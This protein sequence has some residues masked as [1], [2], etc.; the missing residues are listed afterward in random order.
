MGES[1]ESFDWGPVRRAMRNR[2]SATSLRDLARELG[3]MS[4][5]GLQK[6]LDGV[7][8]RR[9]GAVFL[10]WFL[11]AGPR[12]TEEEAVLAAAI[13]VVVG[14]ATPDR[15]DELRTYLQEALL[16]TPR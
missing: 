5:T 9:K 4:P 8:P 14:H 11:T 7:T 10:Q 12:W 1:D 15:R 2:V 3:G 16:M 6:F 13:K